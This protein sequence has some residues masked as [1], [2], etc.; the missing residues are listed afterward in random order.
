MPVSAKFPHWIQVRWEE[1]RV[2]DLIR[3]VIAVYNEI[4]DPGSDKWCQI[5]DKRG[6]LYKRV[7]I[8]FREIRGLDSQSFPFPWDEDYVVFRVYT[9]YRKSSLKDEIKGYLS[10][11]KNTRNYKNNGRR[12]GK[13]NANGQ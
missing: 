3:A 10:L 4:D 12:K 13:Q 1:C 9:D 8:K 6:E 5:D 11:L 2:T 7:K